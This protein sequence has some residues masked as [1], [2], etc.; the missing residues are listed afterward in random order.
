M[1]A[2]APTVLLFE[3]VAQG[4]AGDSTALLVEGGVDLAHQFRVREC[5]ANDLLGIPLGPMVVDVGALRF[6]IHHQQYRR[7]SAIMP[8]ADLRRGE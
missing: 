3:D 4:R 6:G 1:L 2:N 7:G 8:G 5:G